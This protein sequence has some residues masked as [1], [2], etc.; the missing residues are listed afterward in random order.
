ME[1]IPQIKVKRK[2]SE[3]DWTLSE[4][5]IGIGPDRTLMPNERSGVG[6]EDEHRDK[7]IHGETRIENGI[8]EL[9]L[10]D[11]PRF[12]KSFYMD[13]N[14]YLNATK[15]DRF[16][17]PHLLI[18]VK[19]VPGFSNILWHWGN[20]DLDTH[21]C[22]IV[23]SDFATFDKRKGVSAS[24]IKYTEVYPIIYQM[25]RDNKKIGKKTYVEY[26]DVDLAA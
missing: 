13:E 8:Y 18:H 10:V 15:T 2:A 4:F 1:K 5:F 3:A 20:T 16:D 17:K 26:S 25:I 12:S 21:G 14:G 24:K 23:G 6:V 19:D 7:K 11:S 22:Y 9:D